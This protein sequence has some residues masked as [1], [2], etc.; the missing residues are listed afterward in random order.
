VPETS[1]DYIE[2]D[3]DNYRT[4]MTDLPQ[5]LQQAQEGET[6]CSINVV[7]ILLDISGRHTEEVGIQADVT[8]TTIHLYEY[9]ETQYKDYCN[10][11][12]MRNLINYLPLTV[13]EVG[14]LIA[15]QEKFERVLRELT[16]VTRRS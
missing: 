5:L 9:R 12:F 15:S 6:I 13:G 14:E 11:G 4:M 10:G 7:T 3:L 1:N 16:R 2:L 8:P